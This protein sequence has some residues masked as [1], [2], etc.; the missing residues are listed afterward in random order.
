MS[1]PVI[2]LDWLRIDPAMS[3]ALQAAG[4]ALQRSQYRFH[5]LDCAALHLRAILKEPLADS[6]PNTR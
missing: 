5:N 2:A 6:L 3:A 4:A 1:R